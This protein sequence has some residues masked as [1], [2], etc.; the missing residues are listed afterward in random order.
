MLLH[1]A[2][3]LSV[4]NHRDRLFQATEAKM[5]RVSV[6]TFYDYLTVSLKCLQEFGHDDGDKIQA[7]QDN[8]DSMEH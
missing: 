7:E 5:L 1:L 3:Y 4:L 6:S 2:L 8:T